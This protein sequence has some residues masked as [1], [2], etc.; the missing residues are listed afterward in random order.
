MAATMISR[1]RFSN[2]STAF[3]MRCLWRR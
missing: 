2:N 1:V 3:C